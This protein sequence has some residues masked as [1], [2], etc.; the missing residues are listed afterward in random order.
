MIIPYMVQQ[1]VEERDNY[2]CQYCGKDLM[3]YSVT[4]YPGAFYIKSFTKLSGNYI[5]QYAQADP[6]HY[7]EKS[8]H[9]TIHHVAGYRNFDDPDNLTIA[10]G[11]CNGKL[12]GGRCDL[13]TRRVLLT[14]EVSQVQ[15]KQ[16]VIQVQKEK[17]KYRGYR[18]SSIPRYGR[19]RWW[20]SARF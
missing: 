8:L 1:F 17:R 19:P 13:T 7:S 11:S 14:K 4:S 2:T 6:E 10:C 20:T 16:R 18:Y 9:G 15:K 3:L 12:K 5:P